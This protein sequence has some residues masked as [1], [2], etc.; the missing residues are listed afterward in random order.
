LEESISRV[1]FGDRSAAVVMHGDFCF[2]NILYNSRVRRIRLLDPRGYV[3]KGQNSI[4]GDTRYD[5]AK[6]GHSIIGRYDD[7]IAGRYDS[8]HRGNDYEISFDDGANYRCANAVY[9]EIVIGTHR[10]D[11]EEV[12]AAI[13]TLFISMLPLHSD[14][15][16]RQRAFIANAVRLYAEMD[17]AR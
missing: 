10:A 7:I 3:S 8:S 4:F 17:G 15:P 9:R 2:S 12:R 16:D 6:L 13:V 1:D 11:S 5:L 14:R